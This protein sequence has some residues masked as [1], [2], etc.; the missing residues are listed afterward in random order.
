MAQGTLDGWFKKQKT[1]P[2]A[3]VSL[4]EQKQGQSDTEA[5][6]QGTPLPP[7]ATDEPAQGSGSSDTRMQESTMEVTT[8]ETSSDTAA[9]APSL[10]GAVF[11]VVGAADSPEVR[12]LLGAGV[13]VLDKYSALMCT[14]LLCEDAESSEAHQALA[15]GVTVVGRLWV[16][17]ACQGCSSGEPAAVATTPA[18]SAEAP[19]DYRIPAEYCL[20]DDYVDAWDREHV[21]A[22]PPARRTAPH[23]ARR[24]AAPRAAGA[25]PCRPS[26]LAPRPAPT[27]PTAS[28]PH[29]LLASSPHRPTALRRWRG[30]CGCRAHRGAPLQRARESRCGP[31]SAERCTRR[32]PAAGR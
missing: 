9:V 4:I 28:S 7:M 23:P 2:V 25:V 19:A 3:D 22:A 18:A 15:D 10:K 1:E 16:R 6:T 30:R 14:H 31:C 5:D 11:A 8:A 12:L 20:P 26:P 17:E 13:T 32:P 27:V 29:H 21:C 24:A